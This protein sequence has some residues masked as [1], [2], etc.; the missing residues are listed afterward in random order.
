MLTTTAGKTVHFV[1]VLALV[2]IGI[3]GTLGYKAT[4][5]EPPSG[6]FGGL[7]DGACTVSSIRVWPDLPKRMEATA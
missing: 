3:N 5:V 1:G 4:V 2:Y 7:T 6:A